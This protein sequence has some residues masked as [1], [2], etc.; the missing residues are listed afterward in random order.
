MGVGSVASVHA[1]LGGEDSKRGRHS[2]MQR[3]IVLYS[4]LRTV[5]IK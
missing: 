3:L 1:E 5:I 4:F 2:H